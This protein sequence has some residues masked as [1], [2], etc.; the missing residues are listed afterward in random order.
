MIVKDEDVKFFGPGEFVV[1]ALVVLMA[2][3]VQRDEFK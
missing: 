2:A 3:D 1:V